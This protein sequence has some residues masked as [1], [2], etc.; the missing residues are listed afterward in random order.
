[1]SL[2]EKIKNALKL[3]T[4]DP[5][6]EKI[7]LDTLSEKQNELAPAPTPAPKNEDGDKISGLEAKV[8]Q[9]Y[10]ALM[11]ETKARQEIQK[12][13]DAKIAADNK[14]R[15]QA[16]LDNAI[17][18]NKIPA[19]NEEEITKWKTMFEKD[20]DAA[21]FA[22]SKVKGDEQKPEVAQN[23]GNNTGGNMKINRAA[24]IEAARDEFKTT[25]N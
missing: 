24:L 5:D 6:A 10:M 23:P 20:Y 16:A 13:Y 25:K 19:K 11:E 17:K 7:L 18:M 2:I 12:N 3:E 15:I 14:A 9:I 1:M 22:L 8:D 21:E 4:I